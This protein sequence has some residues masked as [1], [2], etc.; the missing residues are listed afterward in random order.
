[1]GWA[2]KVTEDPW[3][4][5]AG[6]EVRVMLTG[7]SGFTVIVIAFDVAGLFEVQTVFDEVS[8]QVTTSLF[9]GI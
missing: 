6:T 5:M 1:V 4:I 2:V 9:D 7:R 8:T 3:Q